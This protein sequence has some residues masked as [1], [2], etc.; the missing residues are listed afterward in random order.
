MRVSRPIALSLLAGLVWSTTVV[1]AG[2]WPQFRGPSGQGHSA[3]TGLPLA[4]S[5]THNVKWKTPVPGRGW[6]SPVVA[7]GRVWMT[8][9][10][11]GKGASLRAI[12]YDVDS[13]REAV[14]VEVFH[15]GSADLTNA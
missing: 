2:D 6:S 15:L 5:E 11:A 10:V 1:R 13:G 4:W 12:A 3:D 9:S 14:N 7:G 8:T